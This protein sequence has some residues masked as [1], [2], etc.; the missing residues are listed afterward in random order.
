MYST[1]VRTT[2]LQIA[3]VHSTEY[4]LHRSPSLARQK[5]M[6]RQPPNVQRDI[7]IAGSICAV[8]TVMPATAASAVPFFA[9]SSTC[10]PI[11]VAGSLLK[12]LPKRDQPYPMH[13]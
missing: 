1:Y 4:R 2:C 12:L 7:V 13:Q 3:V 9:S 6:P 11:A 8:A 5:Y 10:D